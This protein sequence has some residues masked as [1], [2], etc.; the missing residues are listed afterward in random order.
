MWKLWAFSL[1]VVSLVFC[2]YALDV[3]LNFIVFAFK[4]DRKYAKKVIFYS[5]VGQIIGYFFG[6]YFDK[7]LFYLIGTNKLP[8]EE[9][10]NDLFIPL[11]DSPSVQE[12]NFFVFSMLTFLVLTLINPLVK[13]AKNIV[14][15]MRE[16]EDFSE[17]NSLQ[18]FYLS[19]CGIIGLTSGFLLG[20]YDIFYPNHT[21]WEI[22]GISLL[23]WIVKPRLW[24]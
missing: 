10:N 20:F 2:F 1:T 19:L 21:I 13:S 4:K 12:L 7:A 3:L 9:L 6:V 5:L 23:Y 18:K 14:K 8:L 24:K 17:V 22:L 16:G 15:A 11:M